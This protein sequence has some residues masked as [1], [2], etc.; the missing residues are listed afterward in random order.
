[1][2]I[3]LLVLAVC[4]A[5]GALAR[6]GRGMPDVRLQERERPNKDGFVASATGLSPRFPDGVQCAGISS[7]YGSPTRYD[8][9]RRPYDVNGGTHGGMDVTLIEGEP[10]LAMADGEVINKGS[11]SQMEGHFVWLRFPP[12]S[13]GLPLWTF[14][15]YQH[16]KEPVVLDLGAPVKKGDTIGLGGRSGTQG[17][18]YGASG[19][20]HLHLSTFYA[21]G[22]DFTILGR[23]QNM[24]KAVNGVSGD[25]M[26]VYAGSVRTTDDVLSYA[27]PGKQ[28]PV[29][30]KLAD[31]AVRGGDTHP[32]WPVGCRA[33]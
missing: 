31:G 33:R 32:L 9:S 18:H 23:N 13:T 1:M 2:R 28:I 6:S 19:Y 5:T 17:G 11:G 26:I 14:A 12:A 20:P 16:L 29:A 22:P 30:V 4:V 3:A 15:K 7:P 25:P 8:G 27:A 21:D 24:V 10:L